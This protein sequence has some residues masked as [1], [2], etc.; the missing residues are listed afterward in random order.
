MGKRTVVALS[1][2]ATALTSFVLPAQAAPVD[3]AQRETRAVAAVA[4]VK[5]VK[6][7]D[8]KFGPKIVSVTKG[9]KVKWV[10]KG[11]SPH[12]TTGKGWNKS[13][14]PGR[15][16]TRKF[17]KAGTFKYLCTYHDGMTGTVKVK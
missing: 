1:V 13:V 16:Y 11:D 5:I 9:R 10:N 4:A 3:T 7:T 6:M 8:D 2:A 14:N 17:T 15:S 12:T